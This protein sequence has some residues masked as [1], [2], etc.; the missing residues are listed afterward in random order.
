LSLSR[1][2]KVLSSIIERVAVLVVNQFTFGCIH[3]LPVHRNCFCPLVFDY[4]ISVSVEFALI[5]MNEPNE[6]LQPAIIK[7]LENCP[8]AFA[9]INPAVDFSES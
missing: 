8:L 3:N 7:R 6:T 2:A 5:S 4:F 9:Q 1:Q